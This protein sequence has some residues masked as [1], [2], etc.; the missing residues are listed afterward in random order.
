[1]KQIIFS[2]FIFLLFQTSFSQTALLLGSQAP[3][4]I[5]ND[6]NG[7]KIDLKEKIKSGNVVIIFYRGQWCPY[8][9]KHMNQMQ[10]SLKYI[11]DLGA[12][13]IAITPENNENINKMIEKSNAKFS[14][15]YDK[16]HKIMDDYK[17]TFKQ[18]AF[19]KFFHL[20]T[21][22][23]INKTSGNDDDALPIP[24]T[25][26]INQDGKIIGLH[27]DKYYQQRMSVKAITDVLKGGSKN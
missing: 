16:G 5:S 19:S 27:F 24:A 18:S 25:Y 6:Q 3:T 23:N 1:M 15:I 20:L 17:V 9:S 8:C 13:V 4:F 26:I 12:T 2:I 22:T 10:D 11:T 21:G 7:N 14:V